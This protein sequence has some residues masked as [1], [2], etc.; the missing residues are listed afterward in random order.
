MTIVPRLIIIASGIACRRQK[1]VA[2]SIPDIDIAG[3][4]V[5]SSSNVDTH[6]HCYDNVASGIA[7]CVA[8]SIDDQPNTPLASASI[9]ADD[10][11]NDEVDDNHQNEWSWD[12]TSTHPCT[13]HRISHSE[14][15][16]LYG[17]G[18][19]PNLEYPLPI[20]IYP[21][22]VNDQQQRPHHNNNSKFANLTTYKN[23]PT[24]FPPDFQVTLSGSDSLSTHR[25][26][27]PLQQYLSE[28]TT[29]NNG[30]GLTLPT[31]LAN[32]TWYFFGET[33]SSIWSTFLHDNYA[34]PP[35]QSC[36]PQQFQKQ[37]NIALAFGIGNIGSGVQWHIH[38]PGFSETIHGKKHWVLYPPECEPNYD[39]NFASRHWMEYSYSTLEDWT[40]NEIQYEKRNHEEFWQR[41]ITMP[42]QQQQQQQTPP[43]QVEVGCYSRRKP[44]ECTVHEGEVIYFPNLW[45]H[46]TIN[47]EKYTVFVSSF[48]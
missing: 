40:T 39:L 1:V 6:K 13:I 27:I 23:L 48:T 3:I 32:E 14:L 21:D 22:D 24:N 5:D 34:L 45:H 25:R 7:S 43:P 17:P 42:E 37:Q 38:G 28:I 19:L 15:H 20:I 12:P 36:T 11:D 41:W 9:D 31:Q 2:S 8:T 10:G 35:C 44:W 33:H 18:G 29:A 47:L 46:A 16:R 4:S 26:T 30:S